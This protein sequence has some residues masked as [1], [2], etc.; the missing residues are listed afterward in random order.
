[1]NDMKITLPKEWNKETALGVLDLWL[2][3]LE[4]GYTMRIEEVGE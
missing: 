1:M 2:H 4:N 3:A